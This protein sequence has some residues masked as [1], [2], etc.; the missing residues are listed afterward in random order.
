MSLLTPERVPVKVYR[1]DDADA[2]QLDKTPDCMAI[3]FK[4]CLV[5]GYGAK[6]AAGWTM[7]FEDT[8]SGVKVLRPEAS[9]Y[10]DFYL[11]LSADTGTEIKAQVYSNMTDANTGDLK[12]QRADPF[13]YAKK[14]HSNKWLLIAT[15]FGFWF[16]CNQID[17]GVVTKNGAFFGLH[18]LE[19]SDSKK[20]TILLYS[21]TY[22]D[23]GFYPTITGVFENADKIST[24]GNSI[25][26]IMKDQT[27]GVADIPFSVFNGAKQ[28]ADD[29]VFAPIVT[30]FDGALYILPGIFTG[31]ASVLHDN[32]D[33]VSGVL[34]SD[35]ARVF[36]SH[37]TGSRVSNMFFL[38][39]DYWEV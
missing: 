22:S 26:A 6:E 7:P 10:T 33:L 36:I 12:L 15:G 35:D 28:Y 3:I 25:A 39:Q 29:D 17:T 27:V 9:P 34:D 5:T 11:R 32:Y 20:A 30:S 16:F 14:L 1:W 21:S 19:G 4:A 13:K 2:P 18:G 23:G 38:A 8:V 31:A 37:A 24:V